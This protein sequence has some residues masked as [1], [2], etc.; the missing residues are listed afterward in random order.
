MK[1]GVGDWLKV[2]EKIMFEKERIGQVDFEILKGCIAGH[3]Q[4][5]LCPVH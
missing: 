3:H 4:L 1:V 2:T 5:P